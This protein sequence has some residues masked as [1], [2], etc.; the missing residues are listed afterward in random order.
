MKVA[1]VATGLAALLS[2]S[3]VSMAATVPQN[4]AARVASTQPSS[5]V[6]HFQVP[7]KS[8]AP[9]D[10]ALGNTSN[11]RVATESLNGHVLA[12]S[13]LNNTTGKITT[14]WANGRV[15]TVSLSQVRPLLARPMTTSTGSTSDGSLAGPQMVVGGGG[16]EGGNNYYNVWLNSVYDSGIGHT[17]YLWEHNGTTYGQYYGWRYGAGMALTVIFTA[18]ITIFTDGT[19]SMFLKII[20]SL[21]GTWVGGQLTDTIN[22]NVRAKNVIHDYA[23]WSQNQI[24]LKQSRTLVYADIE[25]NN[26]GTTSYQ[27]MYTTGTTE[28]YS[29]MCDQ[30]AYYVYIGA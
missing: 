26:T 9:L 1:S 30:G 7:E 16:A 6:K 28:T 2:A 12:T 27:Y 18:A 5:Q 24:G 21:G 3:G 29:E 22:G 11:G 10:I 8:G 4:A 20:T 14:T 17:G 15:Q 13:V 19:D 25:N 23:V